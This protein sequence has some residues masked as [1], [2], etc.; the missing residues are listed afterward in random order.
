MP[1]KLHQWPELIAKVLP[2]IQSSNAGHLG[3][4][5]DLNMKGWVSSSRFRWTVDEWDLGKS[6]L[7]VP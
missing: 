2:I 4:G 7:G 3:A 5:S 6:N 1:S